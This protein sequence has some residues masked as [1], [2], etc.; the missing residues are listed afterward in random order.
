MNNLSEYLIQLIKTYC[1]NVKQKSFFKICVGIYYTTIHI[2]LIVLIGLVLLLSN[3]IL[4]LFL[5]TIILTADIYVNIACHD[6]LVS[7]M[8]TKYLKTSCKHERM[9]KCL[10]MEI[11]YKCK[12]YY[13]N[14]LDVISNAHLMVGAKLGV[15][16]LLWWCNI[17]NQIKY[18]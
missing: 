16:I 15:T 10:D 18:V 14:Q 12:H 11:V 17:I 1:P 9:I 2:I 7:T 3:N 6:C 13:E 5:L 8:E 4:H